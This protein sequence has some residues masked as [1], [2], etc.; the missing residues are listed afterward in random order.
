MFFTAVC[1]FHAICSLLF[2][3]FVR[4]NHSYLYGSLEFSTVKSVYAMFHSLRV[5]V[6][7]DIHPPKS[8]PV[9]WDYFLFIFQYLLL[10]KCFH[11]IAYP[12]QRDFHRKSITARA[13][14]RK[15]LNPDTKRYWFTEIASLFSQCFFVLSSPRMKLKTPDIRWKE[16]SK[17]LLKYAHIKHCTELNDLYNG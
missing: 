16:C 6:F 7:A 1:V 2:V 4:I 8:I 13:E 11:S 17:L 10:I 9:Q 15:N 3:F 14:E 5:C 12:F